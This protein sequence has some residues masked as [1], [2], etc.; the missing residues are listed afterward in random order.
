[1]IRYACPACSARIK[2][3]DGTVGRKRACPKCGAG[4]TLCACPGCGRAIPLQPHER[5][6]TCSVCETAIILPGYR[7]EPAYGAAPATA[8]DAAEHPPAEAPARRRAVRTPF[9]VLLVVVPAAVLLLIFAKEIGSN[10]LRNPAGAANKVYTRDEFSALL[11]HK[12]QDRVLELLGRPDS[13]QSYG[14]N[15]YWYYSGRSRDPISGKADRLVQVMFVL[16]E[17]HT[18]NYN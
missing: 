11:Y 13:T 12:P 14:G 3:R 6:V 17:V 8:E 1:M 15:E 16:G 18:I 7:T 4:F 10:G 9:W 5:K 2:A